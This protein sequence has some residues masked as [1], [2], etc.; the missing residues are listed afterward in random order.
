MLGDPESAYRWEKKPV[1]KERL[2]IRKKEEIIKSRGTWRLWEGCRA[3]K[4]EERRLP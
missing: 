2:K 1:E 3:N 4:Q